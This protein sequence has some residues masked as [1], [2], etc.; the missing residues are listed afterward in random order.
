MPQQGFRVSVWIQI[1]IN[2]SYIC[3]VLFLLQNHPLARTT[4]DT[5]CVS[6]SIT[7]KVSGWQEKKIN[8]KKILQNNPPKNSNCKESFLTKLTH[9]EA[10]Q[11]Q[12]RCSKS[13]TNIPS[14]NHLSPH[15]S[16][17][18]RILGANPLFLRRVNTQLPD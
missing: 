6:Y 8:K 5:V 7:P 3:S 15:P 9:I 13:L 14:K 1:F 10:L 4:R 17:L 18:T 12:S 2:N 16:T 11:V